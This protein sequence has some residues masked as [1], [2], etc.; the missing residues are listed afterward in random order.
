PAPRVSVGNVRAAVIWPGAWDA[1]SAPALIVFADGTAASTVPVQSQVHRTAFLMFGETV[2]IPLSL[3]PNDEQ[4]TSTATRAPITTPHAP[5]EASLIALEGATLAIEPS[6]G[7]VGAD[8]GRRRRF[9][10]SSFLSGR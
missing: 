8:S 4:A 1:S 2:T 3:D 9:M 7:V 5:N 10:Q 6:I